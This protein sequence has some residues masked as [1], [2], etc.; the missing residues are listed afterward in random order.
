M[1]GWGDNGKAGKSGGLCPQVRLVPRLLPGNAPLGRLR[2][3]ADGK[4]EPS[5]HWVPRREPGNQMKLGEMTV[6]PILQR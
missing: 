5:R 4:A 1:S 6:Q 3:N 2:L